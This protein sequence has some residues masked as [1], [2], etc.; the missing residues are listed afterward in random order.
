VKAGGSAAAAPP[1]DLV[2]LG[3][4]CG[5]YGVKGWVR[6]A[7]RGSDGGVLQN[8]RTWWLLGPG[9]VR[10]V[11]P[12]SCKRHGAALLAKWAGCE[13]KEMAEALKGAALAVPRC[14]FP[15][16]DQ[17]EFYWADLLGCRVVNRVGDDLG[18]VAGLRE[19]SGGQWLEVSDGPD[20]SARLIPLVEQFVDSVDLPLR[21]VRVDWDNEW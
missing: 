2:E 6:V 4:V 5:A 11:V 19:N 14:E 9:G 12:Q 15:P 10:P 21:I 3:A 8:A 7:L 18:V 17:G 13:S 20:G 16:A 1:P